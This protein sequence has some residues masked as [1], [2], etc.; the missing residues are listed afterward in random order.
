MSALEENHP[1]LDQTE[2]ALT[3]MQNLRPIA[4]PDD[5]PRHIRVR[6]SGPKPGRHVHRQRHE[7]L[8]ATRTYAEFPVCAVDCG[9]TTTVGV[10]AG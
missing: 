10:G 2:R 4:L 6:I 8:I 7:L 1:E 5:R 9:R 3:F